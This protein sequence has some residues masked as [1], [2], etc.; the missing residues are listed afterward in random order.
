MFYGVRSEYHSTDATAF[1]PPTMPTR[2]HG[3]LICTCSYEGVRTFELFLVGV[4]FLFAIEDSDFFWH[5]RKYSL[6]THPAV[7]PN[8]K[9]YGASVYFEEV[10][11]PYNFPSIFKL[12]LC[13]FYVQCSEFVDCVNFSHGVCV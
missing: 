4:L 6:S 8:V 11:N 2:L 3:S 1:Y 9:V 10:C 13:I 5:L 12:V 7:V